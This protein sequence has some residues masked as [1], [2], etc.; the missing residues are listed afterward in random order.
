MTH[1]DNL[2]E[3]GRRLEADGFDVVFSGLVRKL[4]VYPPSELPSLNFKRKQCR[5]LNTDGLYAATLC[6]DLS[7]SEFLAYEYTLYFRDAAG[8]RSEPMKFTIAL[9][10][11]IDTIGGGLA[12]DPTLDRVQR[13]IEDSLDPYK[14]G[15]ACDGSGS[16]AGDVVLL[17]EMLDEMHGRVK[18]LE[19][20]YK[21]TPGEN[22]TWDVE[23]EPELL[24]WTPTTA[25]EPVHTA[26]KVEPTHTAAPNWGQVADKVMPGPMPGHQYNRAKE[27]H[28]LPAARAMPAQ[29][30]A[31]ASAWVPT[32]GWNGSTRETPV[33]KGPVQRPFRSR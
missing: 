21:V 20:R 4:T 5:A 3:L 13:I 18:R 17:T 6:C 30:P 19:T 1:N 23:T 8:D 32:Q 16:M 10:T 7:D 33:G 11:S 29:G 28:G 26:A 25:V 22:G 24:Q 9:P 31:K 12:Y 27:V 15:F 14:R 2:E